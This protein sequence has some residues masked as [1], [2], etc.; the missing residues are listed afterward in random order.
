MKEEQTGRRSR[1]RPTHAPGGAIAQLEAPL[2]DKLL[3]T[4]RAESRGE[5]ENKLFNLGR[6]LVNP[7]DPYEG[8]H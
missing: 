8:Q 6:F 4:S 7:E 3:Y 1:S 2:H 5:G